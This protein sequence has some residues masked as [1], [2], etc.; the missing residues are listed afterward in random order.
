[1]DIVIKSNISMN[2]LF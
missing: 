1:M 2:S